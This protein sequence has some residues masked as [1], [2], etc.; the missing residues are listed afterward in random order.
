MLTPCSGA[1]SDR[2]TCALT[3][4][5]KTLTNV[6]FFAAMRPG[7]DEVGF[8]QKSLLITED[9]IIGRREY[10]AMFQ[11]VMRG[12]L[13]VLESAEIG[14]VYVYDEYQA[15]YLRDRCGGCREFT[16]IRDVVPVVKPH[17]GGR[18]MKNDASAETVKRRERRGRAKMR[19]GQTT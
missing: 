11:F 17:K 13:R 18:P 19:G 4:I 14:D 5:Y 15:E 2:A 9:E 12:N 1:S 7:N 16:H 6:A 8:V 10:N 3:D